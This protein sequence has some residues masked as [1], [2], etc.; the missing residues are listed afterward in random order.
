[1]KD[2]KVETMWNGSVLAHNK[3]ES[4]WLDK[5]DAGYITAETRIR[6]GAKATSLKAFVAE[7]ADEGDVEIEIEVDTDDL[8][9][10]L[11]KGGLTADDLRR[12]ADIADGKRIVI[13]SKPVG[14]YRDH[15]REEGGCSLYK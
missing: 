9:E 14:G 8:F 6:Y 15:D 13:D 5:E 12:Y 3:S 4:Y 7:K 10:A 2:E 11:L 1:M